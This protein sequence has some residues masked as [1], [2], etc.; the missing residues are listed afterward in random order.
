MPSTS[1]ND[2]F[3]FR[4]KEMRQDDGAVRETGDFPGS[5]TTETAVDSGVL[6]TQAMAS[7]IERL[8]TVVEE[9]TREVRFLSGL[10]PVSAPVQGENAGAEVQTGQD[11]SLAAPVSSRSPAA[12]SAVDSSGGP[13]AG[14]SSQWSAGGDLASPPQIASGVDQTIRAADRLNQAFVQA[15]DKLA[16]EMEETAAMI[17]Q[18]VN[19]LR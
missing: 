5:A 9:L 15:F 12:N 11:P 6:G 13:S 2:R 7:L 17:E 4:Q 10:M 18:R 19:N 14:A 8:S 3:G 1:L 16:A